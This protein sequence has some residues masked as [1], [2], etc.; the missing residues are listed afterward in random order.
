M[1]GRSGDGV[2]LG[3]EVEAGSELWAFSR[4]QLGAGRG[5]FVWMTPTDG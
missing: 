3:A 4:E 2:P 5:N 1:S